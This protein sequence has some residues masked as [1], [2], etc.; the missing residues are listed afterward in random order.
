MARRVGCRPAWDL[1]TPDDIPL[2][3]TLEQY[4]ALEM[5]DF[6]LFSSDKKTLLK[7]TG[8][9]IPCHYMEY[10]SVDVPLKGSLK[11]LIGNRSSE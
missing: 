3:T 10:Q 2:C 8:C 6:K 1:W 4:N 11:G 5:L 9:L 7:D